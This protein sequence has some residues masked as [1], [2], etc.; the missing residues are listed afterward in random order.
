M[1]ADGPEFTQAE[2]DSQIARLET[3]HTVDQHVIAHLEADGVIDRAAIGNL[4]IALTS[5]RC[6][7]AAVGIIMA[8][9][10]ITEERA[11]QVLR[12]ASQDR[13]LKLRDVAEG[14]LLTGTLDS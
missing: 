2:V 10:K 7:G 14:L 4:E 8:T 9:E 1:D 12:Q 13:N 11:F 5:A 6:I 3:Q